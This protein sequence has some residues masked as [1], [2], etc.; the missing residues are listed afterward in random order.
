MGRTWRSHLRRFLLLFD[1]RVCWDN[2]NWAARPASWLQ[3]M[4]VSE[5]KI[6]ENSRE[7]DAGYAT[8]SR[9][10][11]GSPCVSEL[12]IIPKIRCPVHDH[13]R[14][15]GQDPSTRGP[16]ICRINRVS[17]TQDPMARH[18]VRIPAIG[19]RSPPYNSALRSLPP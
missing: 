2:P 17:E 8:W 15:Q 13:A 19:V 1:I 4:F 5:S 11:I 7:P 18:P 6:K 9:D 3:K 12:E 14:A 16:D 10:V